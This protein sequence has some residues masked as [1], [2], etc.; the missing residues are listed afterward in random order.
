MN[1][2]MRG[3]VST[4]LCALLVFGLMAFPYSST[5]A[6]YS[7]PD[8]PHDSTQLLTNG[9][10][11]SLSGGGASGWLGWY[12]GYSVDS[13]VARS[14]TRSLTCEL[15]TTGECGAYQYIELNRTETKP[16]KV[17]GW[18]K[19]Q[20]ASGNVSTD[21]SL[22]VDLTYVDDSHLYGEAKAFQ[23]GTHDW[24]QAAFYIDPEKPV[25]AVTIY[26]LFRN[27]TGKVWFDDLSVEE[28]PADLLP[29]G[30]FESS[31]GGEIAGW[32]SW[33]SGYAVAAGE[34]RGGSSAVKISSSGTS[35]E[36]GIYRTA[37]L[38]RT[39]VKPLLV[40]GWSKADSASGSPGSS[41][42]IYADVT[43]AD[44]SQE[45]GLYAAFEGGTHDWEPQQLYIVPAK[46]V[47]S[48][49][50]YALFNGR[51]GTV[52][53]DN[54]SLEELPDHV[55]GGAV[56]GKRDPA[57]TGT[58][59]L[60][61]GTLQNVA[62]TAIEG[63]GSFGNGYTIE[64]AGG[65]GGSR[66][67]KLSNTS[68]ADASGIYQ[69]L[70]VNQST[71]KLIVF[72][73]WSKAANVSGDIDRGYALYMDVFYTDGTSQ[74][75]LTAPFATGTQDWTRGQL[76]FQPQ[77]PVQTIS[78]YGIFRDG[79]RGDVWFD[80]FSVK[81]ITT[82]AAVF[83]DAL[84]TPL[85]FQAGTAYTSLQT[86]D[87]LELSLGERG[88]SSLK[89]NS[90]ELA[91]AGV[92]SGFLVRDHE[93]DSDVYAFERLAGNDPG[94]FNGLADQLDL[95]IEADF[96]VLPE[97]IKV[98]GR[99]SD[100]SG[101]DRAVTL[102]FAL[103]VN[104]EGWKWGDYIRGERTIQT[105]Q[106]GNVYSNSQI[107][108]FET[109]PL[110]IYPISAIYNPTTGAG[111]S[112]GTDYNNPTHYRLDYNGSTKQLT[113]TFELGLAPDTANF[114]SAADFGFVI[115]G[116]DGEQGFR[117]AFDKYMDL[118]PEFYEVRIPEQGIWMPF[119]SISDIPD[120]ED[121]GFRFKEGDDDPVDTAYANAND[122]LVFHY[123]ELSSW[124]QSIDP[125]S[126]KT[127]ATAENARDAAAL[128]GEEKAQMAQA[129]A[130][131]NP[132]GDPYLQ[133][134]DTPWNVGALWM[135]NANP[136][137]PGD[138]NGYEMYFSEDKMDARYNTTGPKPD[139]EYL[140]TL[141]GWPYT[142]NYNRDH[143]EYAIAPLVFSKVT[144]RPA[145]HRAFSSWE[146]TVRLA[147]ELH[148]DGRLLM[149]NGT[150][151]AYSM[152]MPWLDAMGNE[153]NWL[154]A[155]D[156]FNP[157]TDETL[158]KYR[159]LSGAKP[160]LMLQNTN[161]SKFG[162][163]YMERYME[164]LLFYG[165]F[166][167]AFSA[168]ADNA[169]N[170]WKN[171]SFYDRDRALFIRYVPMVEA[172]AEAGWEPL[173]LASADSPS[174][175]M[176]RYGEGDEV[177]LTFMNQGT[178]A[179]TSTISFDGQAMG[180]GTMIAAEELTAGMPLSLVGGQ[181]T[182]TLDPDEVKVVKLIAEP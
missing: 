32:G 79:H 113:I 11:E 181:F 151:H 140:D 182:L 123:Q 104:A 2:R 97:G 74:F 176:E 130:M 41:Y 47:K 166:P 30:A 172:V 17:S 119:A 102:T 143:F 174:V 14:G 43:Y 105:G 65:R 5:E 20:T 77:K 1:D 55:A 59:L 180:L 145:I 175:A 98:S 50:V 90:G 156:T 93:S 177:Y 27:K 58:E 137:L 179:V 83:E 128:L 34:G 111:L 21:Y 3:L 84:V 125:Q 154:G 6:Y 64:A 115:Y 69:T 54:F 82:E 165:I 62:G 76:Y 100:L 4:L 57:A 171:A 106:A 95:E 19:A 120:N 66:G 159:T 8:Y 7:E 63:W 75:A 116:F 178:S 153:R 88:V 164:K 61:N 170:Y 38:N 141:D 18:S 101:D 139:G 129:A 173:T 46:P 42:S 26:A 131:R 68:G 135:I 85:P 15:A 108:D 122:I 51:S 134:L 70:H 142:L 103:P 158:S 89:W 9:G 133:W 92:A 124:W 99:L 162:N 127:V 53:F 23:T 167:S 168:T 10:A 148:G 144:K 163:A 86:M 136:D 16:L 87:G 80:D 56:M 126:P 36:Y 160:Y 24:E 48:V 149:A 71:P 96:E 112:L 35:S 37:T 22:W 40:R 161:F 132:A 12:A 72:S 169:T 94:S 73:G 29:G 117:G 78:V 60:A 33:Q 138:S 45:W 157:D 107:P 91:S 44:D 114:P 118:F 49:T 150:P 147:D 121:F 81:E 110:S 109:G 39:A 31:N 155:G 146:A 52:W 25:K 28:L 67:V 152:Y 13:S